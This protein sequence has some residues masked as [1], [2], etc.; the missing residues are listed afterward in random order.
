VVGGLRS[1]ECS[2]AF[3]PF[4]SDSSTR[5]ALASTV[6]VGIA[7]KAK[8]ITLAFSAIYILFVSG[9]AVVLFIECGL[10]LCV[11]TLTFFGLGG[12]EEDEATILLFSPC[13]RAGK[14]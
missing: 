2:S 9:I 3:K 8:G 1:F 10:G 12:V 14:Q 6:T 4:I 11:K 5:P 7:S 13:F